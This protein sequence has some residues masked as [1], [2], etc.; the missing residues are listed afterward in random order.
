[1]KASQLF[2]SALFFVAVLNEGARLMA[3]ESINVTVVGTLKT[4]VIVIG[5]ETTG[6]TITAK[7]ITWELDLAK[8]PAFAE[9]AKKLSGKRAT[10]TGSLEKKAGIEIPV[11]FIVT[12]KS[13]E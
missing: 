10:I 13:I 12:V 8:N 9:A 4:G 7:G 2:A 5:G 6:V 11:R 1:M 3:E